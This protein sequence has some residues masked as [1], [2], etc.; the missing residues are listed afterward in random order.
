[1]QL[2]LH[3]DDHG[4]AVRACDEDGM[5]IGDTRHR[6]SLL[7]GIDTLITDWPVPSLD[8]L[9]MAQLSAVIE[10]QPEILLIGTGQ[11]PALP[12]LDLQ[13]QLLEHGITAEFMPTDA[14]CRTFNVL[15]GEQRR[16]MAA[17]IWDRD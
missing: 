2:N 16:V 4:H 8:A 3:R 14:A 12:R 7:V 11:R 17:L 1:M 9:A 6:H 10:Q 5:L 13:R 15:L